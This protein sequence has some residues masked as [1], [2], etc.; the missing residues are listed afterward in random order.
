MFYGGI[1]PFAHDNVQFQWQ[2]EMSCMF[3]DNE[4]GV[5]LCRLLVSES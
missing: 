5:H 3:D 4:L 1:P 2:V